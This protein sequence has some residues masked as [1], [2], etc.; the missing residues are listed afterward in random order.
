MVSCRGKKQQQRCFTKF[1]FIFTGIHSN[2][3]SLCAF[4]PALLRA[5]AA[6]IKIC[7]PI[8]RPFIK[9]GHLD[10]SK[11]KP[12]SLNYPDRGRRLITVCVSV[13][14]NNIPFCVLILTL[15]N[16]YFNQG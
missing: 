10:F 7:P 12:G 8:F 3:R 16:R 2:D 1:A 9:Q 14:T 15:W 5:H 6:K 11:N 4:V 13:C